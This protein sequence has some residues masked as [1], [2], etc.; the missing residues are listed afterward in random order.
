MNSLN[1]NGKVRPSKSKGRGC[2]IWL[3]RIMVSIM[4][5]SLLG[6]IFE[7]MA[8]A[9]D[10]KAYPPPGQMVDMGGYRLHLNCTG[11]GSPTVVIDAGHADSPASRLLVT[12]ALAKH[13]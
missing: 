5:L 3:G 11:S 12:V 9:A 2:L 10:A 6:Y 13:F 7:P 1:Q 4:G 8:E